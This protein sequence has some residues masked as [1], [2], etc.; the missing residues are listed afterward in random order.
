M[1]QTLT[2]ADVAFE[3]R[4]DTYAAWSLGAAFA[5]AEYLEQVE[6]ETGQ[7]LEFDP[8]A[9]RCDYSEYPSA[10]AACADWYYGDNR[11][12]TEQ[13]AMDWLQNRTVTIPF[14]GGIIVGAF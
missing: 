3:L 12:E 10:M 4:K 14:N 6:Q 2:T 11:P 8:V 5:L 13:D 9:I 1:V 7:T